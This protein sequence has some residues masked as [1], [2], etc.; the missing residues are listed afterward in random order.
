MKDV[1]GMEV[2]RDLSCNKAKNANK[3]SDIK[4]GCAFRQPLTSTNTSIGIP[5]NG[6]NFPVLLAPRPLGLVLT[7]VSDGAV[8]LRFARAY[9]QQ[10]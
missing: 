2:R 4:L 9:M 8:L 3:F 1:A 5:N 6:A 7:V 10:W